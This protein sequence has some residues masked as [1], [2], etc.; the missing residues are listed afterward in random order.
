MAKKRRTREQKIIARLRRQLKQ[1]HQVVYRAQ[2]SVKLP[3]ET[4][5]VKLPKIN[6]PSN[7]PTPIKFSYDPKL[8]KRDLIKTAIL[9]LFFLGAIIF[10]QRFFRL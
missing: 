1:Q 9:S 4:Q 5:P 2:P 3:Q 7:Q 6:E 10:I 8:I